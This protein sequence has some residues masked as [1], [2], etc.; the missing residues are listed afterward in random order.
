MP[1]DMTVLHDRSA[2]THYMCVYCIL[3]LIDGGVARRFSIS[4]IIHI[5]GVLGLDFKI[6]SQP[7][8]YKIMYK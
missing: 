6:I 8:R 2:Y 7:V 5:G 4:N 3:Y 1:P